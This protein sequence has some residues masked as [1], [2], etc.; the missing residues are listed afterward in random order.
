[1]YGPNYSGFAFHSKAIRMVGPVHFAVFFWPIG[2]A[3]PSILLRRCA[4][5]P[6]RTS[7]SCAKPRVDISAAHSISGRSPDTYPLCRSSHGNSG[8]SCTQRSL[9]CAT[10]HDRHPR[11]HHSASAG[12]SGTYPQSRF[13]GVTPCPRKQK[14]RVSRETR[15]PFPANRATIKPFSSPARGRFRSRG[16]FVPARPPALPAPTRPFPVH[17]R[18]PRSAVPPARSARSAASPHL[19][20][21][22]R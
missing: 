20:R 10:R 1:M 9:P 11:P 13:T 19:C 2:R 22:T 5:R 18:S 7:P 17:S 3:V 12:C 21:A 14:R 4:L 6:R 16:D 15:R 8:L